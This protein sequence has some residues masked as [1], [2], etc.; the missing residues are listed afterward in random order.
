MTEKLKYH[1]IC[2]YCASS[3]KTPEKYLDH[4]R[5]FARILAEN[6]IDLI[7][8]GSRSGLMGAMADEMMKHGGRTIGIMPRFMQEVEWH[9]EE[10]TEMIT[11]ETMAGRKEAMIHEVDA[12]VT[13][14]G[15]CGTMEEFMETLSLK[16]LGL[17]DKPMIVL[18]SHGFYNPL[19][20]LLDAMLRDH[21]LGPRHREMWTIVETPHDI[22]PAIVS[23]NNWD[24]DARSFALVQ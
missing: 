23:H 6:H 4:G 11:T 13:F 19:I 15:G 9:H 10:L 20:D 2:V 18:N 8:G 14:P 5:T 1:R 22:L 12:V 21:F 16:R 24:P 17:F 3:N 7:F